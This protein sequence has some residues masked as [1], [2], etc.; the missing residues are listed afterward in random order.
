MTPTAVPP[1]HPRMTAHAFV[2][3]WRRSGTAERAN[4]QRFLAELCDVLDV[5]RPDPTLPDASVGHAIDLYAAFAQEGRVSVAF[6]DARSNRIRLEDLLDEAPRAL[7]RQVWLDP[8]ALDPARRSA[9]VTTD[10]AARLANLAGR[11]GACGRWRTEGA[12]WRGDRIGN[13]GGGRG[14]GPHSPTRSPTTAGGAGASPAARR[15]ARFVTFRSAM[16]ACP[17]SGL[18]ANA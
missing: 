2:E 3:R 6:P 8:L 12:V 15:W 16:A 7:L 14:V 4:Y 5:P 13:G 1:Y 18:L 10:L 11:W 17:A 9:R